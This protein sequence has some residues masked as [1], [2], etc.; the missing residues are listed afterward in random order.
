LVYFSVVAAHFLI[1]QVNPIMRHV[2]GGGPTPAFT[3]NPD[4]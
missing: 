2:G 3:D 4:F 1:K